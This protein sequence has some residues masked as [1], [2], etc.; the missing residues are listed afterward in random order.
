MATVLEKVEEKEEKALCRRRDPFDFFAARKPASQVA[1]SLARALGD[2]DDNSA[3]VPSGLRG[4]ERQ[5]ASAERG[6]PTAPDS[7]EAACT[8]WT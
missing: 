7:T 8:D 2:A 3:R 1:F 5:I 4:T 6:R